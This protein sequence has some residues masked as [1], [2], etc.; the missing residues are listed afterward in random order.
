MNRDEYQA[1]IRRLEAK[2]AASPAAYRK[3]VA[4]FAAVGYAYF[5]GLF[6]MNALL[7]L[8]GI[9]IFC[10]LVASG[11]FAGLRI[12]LVLV[13]GCGVVAWLMARAL[14]VRFPKPE[15]IYLRP[16]DAPKLF[17]LIR[18]TEERLDAKPV[19][20][21][22]LTSELNAAI[23]QSPLFGL[24]GPQSGYLLLGLQLMQ[25][26]DPEEFRA[27][28]AHEFGH[29]SGN[30]GSFAARIYRS[31]ITWT[32]FWESYAENPRRG[33]RLITGFLRWFA[34]RF[35]ARAFVL[36]RANEYEADRCAADMVGAE[37]TAR[38]LMRVSI[39]AIRSTK[40]FW[41]PLGEGVKSLDEP[42]RDVYRKAAAYYRG[43]GA[44]DSA[45]DALDKSFKSAT[46][47]SDTHP[48]LADRV[49]ALGFDA[50]G[51]PED[52]APLAARL[53]Y[54]AQI[55]APNPLLPLPLRRTA[56]EEYLP[57]NGEEFAR[58]LSEEWHESSWLVWQEMRCKLAEA[59]T[60]LAELESRIGDHPLTVDE[61]LER[62]SIIETI[63]DSGP[64]LELYR[65]I[66]AEDPPSAVA[67]F[68]VGRILLDGGDADGIASL[69]EAVLLD[70]HLTPDA[71]E[72]AIGF[73]RER[74]L[75]SEGE[76]WLRRHDD[77]EELCDAALAER[78]AATPDSDYLPPTLDPSETSS[79]VEAA[80][81]AGKIG[82]IWAIRHD[83]KTF[84]EQHSHVVVIKLKRRF[85]AIE[86]EA[87]PQRI[88][89]RVV[90]EA[91]VRSTFLVV[92]AWDARWAWERTAK[93]VEGSLI[94]S[95]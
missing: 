77:Y 60:R 91:E 72:L 10:A 79:V 69:E 48:G 54:A 18:E 43:L 58:R 68:H 56:A 80:K 53:R 24:F 51:V 8:M 81:R 78:N 49:A 22:V 6:A 84:P 47:Y 5:L 46:D 35:D 38:A 28:V 66:L 26:L 90:D 20:N 92:A 36:A 21:V 50:R 83:I 37:T 31:R 59:R 41:R 70:R 73:L 44:D 45:I 19:Q 7:A 2:S 27:V 13:A 95:R 55:A 4:L 93:K 25:A 34:P 12:V 3:S 74:G 94:Y 52:L 89:G 40:E 23:V 64:A 30:H 29:Y 39:S 57:G 61:R 32:R 71:C 16:D 1:M 86:S 87:D 88:A 85:F 82:K 63:E 65:E 15:G 62:A 75:N 67:H 17:E 14:L 76:S 9:A 11:G 33:S 42:P